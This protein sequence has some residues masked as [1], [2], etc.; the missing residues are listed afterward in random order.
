MGF[1]QEHNKYKIFII[2]QILS[3]PIFPTFGKIKFLWKIRTTQYGFLAT[4]QK[5]EKTNDT[6]PRKRPDRRKDGRTL[7][8]RTLPATTGVQKSKCL[9]KR[10]IFFLQIKKIDYF[11]FSVVYL[12]LALNSPV[13]I[14][15]LIH[16]NNYTLKLTIYQKII[17]WLK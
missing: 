11:F 9:V 1:V 5:L 10:N 8:H 4:C 15:S 2:E 14:Y 16:A 7:F 6:S 17:F 13:K 3:W 12:T